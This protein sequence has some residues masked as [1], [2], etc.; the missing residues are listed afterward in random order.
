MVFLYSLGLL[1]IGSGVAELLNKALNTWNNKFDEIIK[2]VTESPETF[3][4]GKI[5][6]VIVDVNGVVQAIG[7]GL[8]VVFFLA[9][10]IKTTMNFRD[11]QHWQN[12]IGFFIRFILAKSVITYG[13]DLVLQVISFVQGIISKIL[14]VANMGGGGATALP[15][16]VTNAM[17]NAGL[18][19]SLGIF[20]VT[21]IG[22]LAITVLSFVMILTVYG[23]FF[24][25][26]MYAAV[27]PL[28]LSTL[29]GEP[30]QRIGFAFIK[31]FVG[32]ALQ[33]G[34]IVLCCIIFS[35]FATSAPTIDPSSSG[36]SL[37]WDYLGETI[38][39]MLILVGTVKGSDMI[40]R[41]MMGL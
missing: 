31:S 1:S 4:E 37:V 17:E 16:E 25:L 34:I 30:T 19:A 18:G 22:W 8:L 7:I 40:V 38:F 26:Y 35:A 3:R 41:N 28:P 10:L 24:K 14:Q 20:A 32:V 39:N 15:P 36:V 2:I 12:Y 9:G 11:L 5:W 33:G 23:R 27:S 21:L 13:L 29:A 6:R